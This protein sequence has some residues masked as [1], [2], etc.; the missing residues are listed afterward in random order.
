MSAE[1]IPGDSGRSTIERIV[2]PLAVIAVCLVVVISFTGVAAAFHA[3][4]AQTLT[5]TQASDHNENQGND[6]GNQGQGNDGNQGNDGHDHSDG[7]PENN[8]NPDDPPCDADHGH[9]ANNSAQCDDEEPGN[10]NGNGN[11][12]G[13]DGELG[14]CEQDGLVANE[15]IANQ[16]FGTE[17]EEGPI[18]SE[19][20]DNED[21]FQEL[22]VVVHEGSCVVA[23]ID[24]NA[25]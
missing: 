16:V 13:T 9:P 19:L 12:N 3:A 20:H 21:E 2:V 8:P 18:S 14:S 11:G 22:G 7:P 25:E 1:T 23:T 15:T 10:G 6:D 24:N 17:N 5:A 4:D